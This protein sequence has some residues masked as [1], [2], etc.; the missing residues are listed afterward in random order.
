MREKDIYGAEG[1]TMANSS[2]IKNDIYA[3]D[4]IYAVDHPS[5]RRRTSPVG[6]PAACPG[7]AP[8]P[9]GSTA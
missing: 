2:M 9:V 4:V 6:N 7:L 3:R 1:P 5:D 8:T